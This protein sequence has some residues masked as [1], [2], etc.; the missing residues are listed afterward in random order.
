MIGMRELQVGTRI[1]AAVAAMAAT[2]LVVG[3]L[4][5]SPPTATAAGGAAATV[6]NGI[7]TTDRNAGGMTPA[8]AGLYASLLD[9]RGGGPRAAPAHDV[10]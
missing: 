4:A 1:R 6:G 5:L 9:A 2:T 10:G 8:S 3:V 7:T